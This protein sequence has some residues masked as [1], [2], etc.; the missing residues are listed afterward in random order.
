MVDCV[1]D[2]WP[3]PTRSWFKDQ[4]V[5]HGP[6]RGPWTRSWSMDQ[7]VVQ[8]PGRGP[9]TRSWSKD[10]VQLSN[11]SRLSVLDNGSLVFESVSLE[12]GGTYVCVASSPLGVS[13]SRP[14]NVT[15]ACSY[16]RR[17][18]VV[19]TELHLFD[20]SYISRESQTT[21]NVLWSR[22]SVRVSVCP[23]PHAYTIARTRM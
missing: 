19:K 20:Y 21:R 9:R 17:L 12:N 1:A 22:V 18:V 10:G 6:S 2:G 5:V 15:V 3:E 8:G 13:E 4:V 11:T 23:R 14:L 16:T 7:V